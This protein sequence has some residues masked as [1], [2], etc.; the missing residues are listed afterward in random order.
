M[1][2]DEEGP[3]PTD[4]QVEA[5]DR[6]IGDLLAGK[7]PD[8]PEALLG[9]AAGSLRMAS[10]L[11]SYRSA[12]SVPSHTFVQA[13]RSRFMPKQK[14]WLPDLRLS[15][16]TLLRGFSGGAAAVVVCL[17]G[18]QALERIRGRDSVPAGWVPVAKAAEL[19]PGA[20]KRFLAN[21]KDGHV[22]NI[23]G[24]IW[25]LS[26]ICTHQACILNWNAQG[27]AFDCPC[28]GAEFSV[29]GEHTNPVNYGRPLPRLERIPVQQLNGVIYVVPASS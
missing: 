12:D 2:P 25:A 11:S 6:C 15:R 14:S 1:T 29:S 21:D 7:R 20:V 10:L 3:N 23:G 9:E 4:E 19:P 27:Q 18:Q 13:L 22:M 16:R 26:A 24:H 28:H 8:N 17:F 5:L